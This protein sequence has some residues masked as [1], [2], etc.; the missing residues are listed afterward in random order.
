[1]AE[2]KW[3]KCKFLID[4]FPKT[5]ESIEVYEELLIPKTNIAGIIWFKLDNKKLNAKILQEFL[6]RN[7]NDIRKQELFR[8][9]LEMFQ[10]AS[11]NIIL[12]F[13]KN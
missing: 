6:N 9:R 2:N 7:N 10:E 3:E 4:G 12:Q 13:Q 1:M 8:K 11:D 5:Q